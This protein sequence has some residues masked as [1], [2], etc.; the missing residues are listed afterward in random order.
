MAKLKTN[1]H[2]RR[3]ISHFLDAE[4]PIASIGAGVGLLALS[5]AISGRTVAA[6]SALEDELKA[7]GAVL[8]EMPQEI[9]GNILTANGDD[10]NAAWV[11]EAMEFFGDAGT[12]QARAA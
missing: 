12:A 1:L 11:D 9:D 3:I 4:K 6:P 2:T 8:S 7:A 10:I 5:V